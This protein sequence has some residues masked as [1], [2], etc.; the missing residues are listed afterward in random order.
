MVKLSNSTLGKRSFFFFCVLFLLHL[1]PAASFAQKIPP[2][3]FRHIT[4]K[5]MP[6]CDKISDLIAGSKGSVWICTKKG[7]IQWYGTG[8]KH[9]THN[10]NDTN[11]LPTNNLQNVIEDM[12]GNLWMGSPL[13]LI[14]MNTKTERF[15]VFKTGTTG[16]APEYIKPFHIDSAGRVWCLCPSMVGEGS[17]RFFDKKHPERLFVS[18]GLKEVVDIGECYPSATGSNPVY[19]VGKRGGVPG[20]GVYSVNNNLLTLQYD[21]FNGK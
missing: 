9:Y 16:K 18:T 15:E 3:I 5:D 14:Q 1:V 2:F 11:S 4:G 19:F 12:E 10:P 6:Y 7:L 17:I 8:Y 13:G 20:I 21:M